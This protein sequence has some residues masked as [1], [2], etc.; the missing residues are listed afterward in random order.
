MKI[1]IGIVVALVILA[2]LF[3]A[4]R[5][6]PQ[7]P[8]PEE[9]VQE[10]VLD[11]DSTIVSEES[12]SEQPAAQKVVREI[13]VE[14]GMMYF[15][16]KEIEV[17]VGDTVRIVYKNK[18][19]RHDWVIDEFNARTKILGPGEEETIEFVANRAGSFE[20]YCSVGNHRAMGMKGTLVVKE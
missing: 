19:G 16:P 10:T 8:T 1:G 13:L 4:I 2:G 12:T 18:D 7:S 17:Q 9:S 3:V 6:E 5:S 14:G 20:Y 11:T 15:N